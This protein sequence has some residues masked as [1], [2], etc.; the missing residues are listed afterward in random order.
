M[1]ASMDGL[2]IKTTEAQRLRESVTRGR[3]SEIA[4]REAQKEHI[5]KMKA[6]RQK[7]IQEKIR[8]KGGRS[9]KEV[10]K[11]MERKARQL[12]LEQKR[13]EEEYEEELAEINR[14]VGDRSLQIERA[15]L[16]YFN[17]KRYFWL[18]FYL[19]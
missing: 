14:K 7:K 6:L 4:R 3:L 12:R 16:V 1:S 17:M 19:F 2:P 5:E 11:E 8:E 10:E 9:V 13:R 18:K 15:D